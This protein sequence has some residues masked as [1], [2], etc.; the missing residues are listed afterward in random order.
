M[1]DREL[2][3]HLFNAVTDA[4]RDLEQRNYGAAQE[5]LIRGQQECE[6]LYLSRE[7]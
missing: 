2:Y 1:S 5:R 3:L 7:E 4:L 6:E